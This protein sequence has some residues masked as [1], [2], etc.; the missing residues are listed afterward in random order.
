MKIGAADTHGDGGTAQRK[1]TGDSNPDQPDEQGC[2]SGMMNMTMDTVNR[3]TV[4]E[5]MKRQEGKEEDDKREDVA[6]KTITGGTG[7]GEDAGDR[8]G[9][10]DWQLSSSNYYW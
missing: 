7:K 1:R 6:A 4:E 9:R 2:S 10:C 3:V 8:K 5:G